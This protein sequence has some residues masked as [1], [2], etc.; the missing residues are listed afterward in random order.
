MEQPVSKPQLQKPRMRDPRL[1]FF[2]GISMFIIFIAHVPSNYWTLWI[3]ARFGFSDA[4]EIF[5][6]CSGMASAMAFGAVYRDQGW[7]MGTSRIIFRVWQ[8]YWVH[9]ALFLAIATLMVT[10]NVLNLNNINYV[11]QLN[12]HKFFENPEQNLLGLM[13]L[14]YVPNYFDILPMY[15]GILLLL[16]CVMALRIFGTL[17]AALFVIGLWLIAQTSSLQLPAEPW[18][19]RQWF[20]NPFGWQLIF[21]T[22]FAFMA[23]W[24]KPPPINKYLITLSL[25]VLIV[26]FPFAYYWILD[27]SKFFMDARRAIDPMVI[28]TTF[29]T[30]KYSYIDKTNLGI[31]RYLHF[32]ALAYIFWVLAGPNGSR[33]QI[34]TGIFSYAVRIIHKVGQQALATFIVGMFMAQ[35]FGAVLDVIGRTTLTYT[36]VNLGGFLSLIITAYTVSWF[37]SQPWKQKSRAKPHSQ[38]PSKIL[39][40]D[41]KTVKATITGKVLT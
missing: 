5:V 21:F 6:F 1:D 14:T 37:K 10:L 12:L 41:G 20:F 26:T 29:G 9:L 16:P 24:I 11:S 2:R 18:S 28:E 36:F 27:N 32:L 33:L 38:P 40:E 8:V 19:D 7:P 22:G 15:I 13:T 31:L 23:G 35:F 17:P 3:P 30:L 4:T 34:E 39:Y 25:V